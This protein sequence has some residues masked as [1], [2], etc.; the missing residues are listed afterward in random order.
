[1]FLKASVISGLTVY[2]FAVGVGTVEQGAVCCFEEGLIM[3]WGG[4]RG[5]VPLFQIS[6]LVTIG[7][8]A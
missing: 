1:M 2:S 7:T 4:V 8:P 3:V 6:N 5:S